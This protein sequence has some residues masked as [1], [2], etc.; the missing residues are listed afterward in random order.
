MASM[1]KVVNAAVSRRLP[2][3]VPNARALRAVREPCCARV[4]LGERRLLLPVDLDVF[5]G[6]AAGDGDHD[7]YADQDRDSD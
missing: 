2:L 7:A 6:A 5:F 1:S 4:T 3:R